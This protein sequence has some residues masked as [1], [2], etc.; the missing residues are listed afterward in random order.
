MKESNQLWRRETEGPSRR[1]R[2][3]ILH[4]SMFRTSLSLWSKANECRGRDKGE[5]GDQVLQY[6]LCTGTASISGPQT[7]PWT[8]Q[9]RLT[10][11][12]AEWLAAPPRWWFNIISQHDWLCALETQHYT[13]PRWA[14][15]L[16][17]TRYHLFIFSSFTLRIQCVQKMCQEP[18]SEG[19]MK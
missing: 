5:P 7:R 16:W 8:R 1:Q 19:E 3:R 6:Q 12:S 15:M 14:L 9:C 11:S 4:W 18:D 10:L 2:L 17:K 13:G